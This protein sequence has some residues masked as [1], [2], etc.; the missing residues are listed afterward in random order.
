MSAPSR[1]SEAEAADNGANTS[2]RADLVSHALRRPDCRRTRRS[3][4]A[5][6]PNSAPVIF[7]IAPVLRMRIQSCV[8]TKAVP[9]VGAKDVIA[10]SPCLSV[11]AQRPLRAAAGRAVERNADRTHR[12]D[13][14]P[15][16]LRVGADSSRTRRGALK[17]QPPDGWALA[18]RT[19]LQLLGRHE[20]CDALDDAT[21]PQEG[22]DGG[23]PGRVPLTEAPVAVGREVTRRQSNPPTLRPAVTSR[24]RNP[25]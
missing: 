19:S 7:D 20:R 9:W 5:A 6:E 13:R 22:R 25:Q 21:R 4:A 16:K 12:A 2:K 8:R 11:H 14:G 1:A 18:L 23:A 17:G 15:R 24:C 10:P 3:A